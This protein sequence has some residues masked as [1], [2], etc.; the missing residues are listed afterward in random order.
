M[1]NKLSNKLEKMP[2]ARRDGYTLLGWF[3]EAE[4][5]DRVTL[6][7][8]Y[9]KDTTVYAH[10]ERPRIPNGK[11]PSR[12]TSPSRTMANICSPLSPAR[13]WRSFP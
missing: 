7:N 9:T 11:I 8:V 3:T 6:D 2:T 10:W 13:R 5:G 12:S 1:A 4:G